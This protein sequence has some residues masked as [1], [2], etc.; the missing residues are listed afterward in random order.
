LKLKTF[1]LI[2]KK[3]YIILMFKL[4]LFSQTELVIGTPVNFGG[5]TG[6]ALAVI[7]ELK[8]FSSDIKAYTKPPRKS[9]PSKRRH[10]QI[11][12]PFGRSNS[13]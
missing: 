13:T 10:G 6:R 12:R 8:R 4:K 11:S 1:L 7:L 5:M 2:T 9:F 3:N